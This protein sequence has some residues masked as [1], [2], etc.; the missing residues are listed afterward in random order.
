MRIATEERRQHK[1]YKLDNSVSIS[2]QGIFQVT[3]LSQG[4]FCFRC[5]PYTPI[6]DVFVTDILSSGASIQGFSAKRAW[7]MMTE[8]STHKH[9]PTIVGVKFGTLTQEQESLLLQLLYTLEKNS[10]SLH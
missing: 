9:L 10:G 6:T 2:S 4:G 7:V 5:P 1:R 3:D 8:N